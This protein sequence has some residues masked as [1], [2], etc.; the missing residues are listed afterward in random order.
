MD[1]FSTED[2][3]RVAS[4]VANRRLG[5][6]CD[7]VIFVDVPKDPSAEMFVRFFNTDGSEAESCGNGSRALGLW[8]MHENAKNTVTFQSVGGFVTTKL[9]D[10]GAGLVEMIFPLPVVDTEIHLGDYQMYSDP[11]PVSVIVGNPHVVL[12]VENDD[13]AELWGRAI[14]KLPVFPAGTNVNFVTHV[15]QNTIHLTV[16]E[17]GAGLT[18]ACGTGAAG[19][20]VAAAVRGL[21]DKS[22]PITVIQAGGALI[23]EIKDDCF[24]QRGQAAVVFKGTIEFNTFA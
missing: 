6:G 20:V 24:V 11:S 9:I 15:C 3:S 1:E 19:T 14:E 8:W 2:L 12:F 22:Q 10:V 13:V 7:Q 5:V 18:P 4:L 16:W 17:R 21:V 23:I